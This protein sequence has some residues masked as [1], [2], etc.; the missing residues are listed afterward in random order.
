MWNFGASLQFYMMAFRYY[1]HPL[2]YRKFRAKIP[3]ILKHKSFLEH[4]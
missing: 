1:F 3:A 2:T 4:S